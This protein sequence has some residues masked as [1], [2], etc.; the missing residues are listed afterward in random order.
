[1]R[2]GQII[3]SRVDPS[4][5]TCDDLTRLAID[6]SMIIMSGYCQC[7]RD[8]TPDSHKH[9]IDSLFSVVDFLYKYQDL[10]PI[11]FSLL[12]HAVTRLKALLTEDSEKETV[13]VYLEKAATIFQTATDKTRLDPEHGRA[14]YQELWE[15]KA[16]EYSQ[17]ALKVRGQKLTVSHNER[18]RDLY[19]TF[20]EVESVFTRDLLLVRYQEYKDKCEKGIATWELV[21]TSRSLSQQL[22]AVMTGIA[23]FFV[24]GT[25]VHLRHRRR[26]SS[27][28][29]EVGSAE[30]TS[31]FLPK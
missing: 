20:A 15:S 27:V 12:D 5:I 18:M 28:L 1:M 30:E 8:S 3:P 9:Y 19:K 17:E 6:C 23:T 24:N 29:S 11:Y 25:A 13:A 10:E 14:F 2:I 7:Q 31:P 22:K 21:V 4:V 16:Q 26:H